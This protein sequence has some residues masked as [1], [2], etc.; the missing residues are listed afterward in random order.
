MT[1]LALSADSIVAAVPEAAIVLNTHT[2]DIVTANDAACQLLGFQRETPPRFSRLL[3]AQVQQFLVFLDELDTRGAAWTRQVELKRAD[4]HGLR[5]EIR[6]RPLRITDHSVF[7]TIVDLDELDRRTH[8]TEVARLQRAGVTE[9]KRAEGFFADLERRNQLILN[10][11]GEGIYGLNAEG[12]ATFVNRAA[13]EMLGWTTDDLLGKDIHSILH[14][15]HVN[16]DHYHHHDCPI[17]K[18][19]R[20]EQV[21]RIEDEVFWRKDGKP[22]P[23]EYIST[24]I[25]DH[26]ILA[27]AVVIFRDI[28]E[29][30]ES[31]RKLRQAMQ[32]VADLRDRLEQENAY[33]QE[34]I[35]TERAHHAIIGTST[36]IAQTL[37]R[38]DLVAGTDAT[39]MISGEHGTGKSLVAKEIHKTSPRSRRPLIHFNCGSVLPSEVEAELFGQVR[40]GASGAKQDKPGKLEL[41]HGG[42]LFLDDVEDLP[43]DVQGKLLHVLQTK[44]VRRLGDVRE[45]PLDIRV[46]AATTLSLTKRSASEQLREQLYMYLNLFPITCAPLRERPE[47][48]PPLAAHLLEIACAK[49]NR[50]VPA[51]TER[52][53][54]RLQSYRWP[55]NVRE[56]R[57]VI[58]RAAILST[59]DKL[60]IELSSGAPSETKSVDVV[61]TEAEIQSIVRANVIAAM[62][63]TNGKVSGPNGAASLLDI[64]PT[65]LYSR[66]K[67]FQIT[68]ADWN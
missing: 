56:L 28:S 33:L 64:R 62:R 68:H 51:I 20:F 5:C 17:Y 45:K 59:K 22:I 34:E 8:D 18:S 60:R 46:I 9:W 10:A 58:E 12:K 27:G 53:M 3:G 49:L 4:G 57:N 61:K 55:G 21:N 66:I 43:H 41:A 48:I 50:P 19:F 24:P 26:Q 65:T 67:A 54:H 15:T 25:Y 37:A 63:S 16:G 30:K 6:G 39:V 47:D 31:E 29:R 52:A 42:T 23:V 2:D 7:L 11:A 13:Q 38:I 14:H 1:Q 32:E 44:S 35:N 36:A 40:G